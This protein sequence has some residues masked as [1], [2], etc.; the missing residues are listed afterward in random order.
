[1]TTLKRLWFAAALF[2]V[3]LCL[4]GLHVAGMGKPGG[5]AGENGGGVIYFRY[6]NKLFTMNDDGSGVSQV[7]GF[8]QGYQPWGEPSRGL[9]AGKRWFAQLQPVLGEIDPDGFQRD[10]FVALSDSGDVVPLPIAADL[11]PSH[12]PK[13]V[14]GDEY[15]SWVGRRWDDNPSSPT[16]GDIIEG[17]LYITRLAFDTE[18]NITGIA[19][20]SL[21]L[22]AFDLV[23]GVDPDIGGFDWSPDGT[24]FVFVSV[25]DRELVIA[26][27][28]TETFDVILSDGVFSSFDQAPRWSPAGD[29]IQVRYN[30]GKRK[31]GVWVMNVDGTGLKLLES[32][33]IS[34]SPHVG[35]W[36]PTGSHL[37]YQHLDLLFEDSYIVRSQSDGRRKVRITDRSIGAGD[38][39]PVPLGWRE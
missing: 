17:G 18:G 32:A 2:A 39:P 27:L 25:A 28:L 16:F 3:V 29:R 19:E 15:I 37:L 21:L 36:S 9:L 10:V 23:E 26:D 30:Q 22:V 38:S 5:G 7:T 8:P 33:R 6:Y 35:P 20:P 11:D 1:M 13:W 12:Q 34:T 14:P 24:A 31:N 4:G